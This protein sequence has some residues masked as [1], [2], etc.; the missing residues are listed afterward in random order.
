MKENDGCLYFGALT[1]K[2]HNAIVSDPKPYRRDVKVMLA[3]LLTMV[4]ALGLEEVIIDRP[5][6][7]QR[8]RLA[9]ATTQM[10]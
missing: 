6:Y 5:N 3:N 2:L 1:E 4:E 7:S 8:I 9:S 10:D